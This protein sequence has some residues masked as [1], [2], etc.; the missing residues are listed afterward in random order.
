V[1]LR[2]GVSAALIEAD[3]RSGHGRVWS[4][5]LAALRARVRVRAVHVD[6]PATTDYSVPGDGFDVWLADGHGGRPITD[7]PVVAVVHEMAWTPAQLRGLEESSG[8]PLATRT[9][10]GV[11]SASHVIVPSESSRRQVL[12][13][14]TMA[15][16]RVHAV[17]YGVNSAVFRPDARGGHA[18]VA[19]QAAT[20][21]RPYVL[22]V[23]SLHPRKNLA[24]LRDAMGALAAAGRSHVLAVVVADPGGCLPSIG[25][26]GIAPRT[27]GRA[28]WS[29]LKGRATATLVQPIP[30]C[31]PGPQR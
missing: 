6:R 10:A 2:V 16:D 7:A 9:A 26:I 14:S 11:G 30:S 5:T 18:L 3:A 23:G 15:P 17:P 22:F 12:D 28:C 21:E 20:P 4:S 29:A 1:T 24:V 19:R 25:R 31:V 27:G 13:R 8:Q